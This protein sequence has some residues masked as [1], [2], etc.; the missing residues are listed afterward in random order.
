[1]GWA[2]DA[3]E[4]VRRRRGISIAAPALA[5]ALAVG[6]LGSVA[7]AQDATPEGGVLPDDLIAPPRPAHVHE[8]SCD[9]G[10]LGGIV[11]PL[12]DLTDASGAILGNTEATVAASSFTSVPLPLDTILAADH[13]I[14]VHLSEEEIEQYIACGEIGGPLNEAG[15]LVIGLKEQQRSG[16][17]G[18]AFLAPGAD[19]AST[20]ISVFV[21][22][23]LAERGRGQA[24][25]EATPDAAVGGMTDD[26]EADT[27]ADVGEVGDEGGIVTPPAEDSLLDDEGALG[28]EEIDGTPGVDE[29]L[30]DDAAADD[31]G[32]DEAAEDDDLAA[33]GTPEIDIDATAEADEDGA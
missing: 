20:D 14:N 10:E 6:G 19:G 29:G 21:A 27:D 30:T 25:Q 2:T 26:S 16:F 32:T 9:E 13:A 4:R 12:T 1:M 5:A 23:D 24:A 11:A 3:T 22:E 7:I 17:A 31:T 28:T 33:D 8:G 15:N 18:I